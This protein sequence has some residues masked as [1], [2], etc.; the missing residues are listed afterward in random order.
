VY[1]IRREFVIENAPDTLSLAISGR[2]NDK[3]DHAGSDLFGPSE[4]TPVAGP[5][6]SGDEEQN[7]ATGEFDLRLFEAGATVPF[8]LVS[9]LASG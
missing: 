3:D 9:M 4:P 8:K 2:D 6:D 5:H 7:V 1:D